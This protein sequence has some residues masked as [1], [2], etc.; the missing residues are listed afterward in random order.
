M[1]T[2]FNQV[3]IVYGL[4]SPESLTLTPLQ[5]RR[6]IPECLLRKISTLHH[7]KLEPQ[8]TVPRGLPKFTW[9][10]KVPTLRVRFFDSVLPITR[11][12]TLPD[13]VLHASQ[14]QS[15]VMRIF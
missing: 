13:S 7:H 14:K 1:F 5:M 8:D 2:W 11:L 9:A 10:A 15:C 6:N 4:R 12:D 3:R